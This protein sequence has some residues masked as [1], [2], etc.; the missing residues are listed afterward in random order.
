MAGQQ[1]QGASEA[2][3]EI[4]SDASQ[5][6]I[7]KINDWFTRFVTAPFKIIWGDRR[8]A[9]GLVILIGYL[10]MATVGTLLV[11]KPEALQGPR[12]AQPFQSL[13]YP[14]GTNRLGEDL[15]ALIVHSTPYVLTMMFAGA[16][17]TAVMGVSVGTYAGYRGGLSDR[18]LS[19]ISD[20]VIVIPG[21]PL[22]IVISLFLSPASPIIIGIILSINRWAGLARQVRS[23]VLSIRDESYVEASRV[24]GISRIRIMFKDILPNIMPFVMIRFVNA[25]RGVL[26]S[27]VALYFLGI[28][29]ASRK[30]WGVIMRKAYSGG[31]ALSRPGSYHWILVPILAVVLISLGL[32]M[33]AQGTDRLFNPRVRARHVQDEAVLEDD[34][35]EGS[36]QAVTETQ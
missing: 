1:E 21:L 11:P 4:V 2:P 36:R 20:V 5:T 17:F 29:P 30:T 10:L 16:L 24:I 23:Q 28:L 18:I 6:R 9:F 13:D 22:F 26:Y 34:E 15:F 25:A 32:V 19:T 35:E 7:E 27:S 12:L 33:F 31:N 8:A 14:L 3:F